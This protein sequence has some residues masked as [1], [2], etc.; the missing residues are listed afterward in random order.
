M[1]GHFALSDAGPATERVPTCLANVLGAK[2]AR[3]HG[4]QQAVIDSICAARIP[5]AEG[6]P[7]VVKLTEDVSPTVSGKL[8]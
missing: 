1:I 6:L 7:L 3:K 8:A 5:V 4:G 2:G